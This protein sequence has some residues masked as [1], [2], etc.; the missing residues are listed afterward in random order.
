[1]LRAEREAMTKLLALTALGLVFAFSI[2]HD[3]ANPAPHPVWNHAFAPWS[4]ALILLC[5]YI[6][7]VRDSTSSNILPGRWLRFGMCFAM[8]TNTLF[9]IWLRVPM[10][11]PAEWS[12]R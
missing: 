6:S 5:A 1:M 2:A 4:R 8:A 10:L 7:V 9:K 11:N 3:F 12:A